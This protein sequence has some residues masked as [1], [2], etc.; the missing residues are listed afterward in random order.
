MFVRITD[1]NKKSELMLM[2]RARAYS[3]SCSP[4]ILVY[5]HPFRHNS[6]FCSQKRWK[7][8]QN[9]LFLGFK[10]IQG[11]RRWHS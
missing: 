6:L 2:R 9:A 4:V 8:Y 10:V 1:S 3:S 7:N 11:H 5:L